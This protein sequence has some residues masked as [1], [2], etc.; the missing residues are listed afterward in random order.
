[1][2]Y[3]LKEYYYP[4][5]EGGFKARI[6]TE[7]FLQR[8][9]C[10]AVDLRLNKPQLI[11]AYFA[12]RSITAF[13]KRAPHNCYIFYQFYPFFGRF[14]ILFI[15]LF[16]VAAKAFRSA[17]II[18]IMHDINGLRVKNDRTL[19]KELKLLEFSESIICLND[20][21]EKSLQELNV[22]TKMV[23]LKF[24]DYHI[25]RNEEFN[26]KNDGAIVFAGNL[27]KSK[28]IYQLS[29]LNGKHSFHLYG[30]NFDEEKKLDDDRVIYRGHHSLD[31]IA[32]SI[33]EGSYGLVW[34][35]NSIESCTGYYGEYLQMNTPHKASLYVVAELPLIVWEKAAIAKLVRENEIGITINSLAELSHKIDEIDDKKYSLFL[36]NL[37]QLKQKLIQGHFLKSAM[38]E[39]MA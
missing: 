18:P 30:I 35:G 3:Y 23:H 10:K 37:R 26:R 22:N 19:R 2:K 34:D 11:R 6:D 39:I 16:F 20:S 32:H 25:P 15:K 5:N 27:F 8:N 4:E 13:L 28:F 36:N 7:I 31:E 38:D 21:M 14:N 29:E 1:M 24:W 17:R 12:I 9:N 33:T